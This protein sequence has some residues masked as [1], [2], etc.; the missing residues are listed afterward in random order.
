MAQELQFRRMLPVLQTTAAIFLGG[1]GLWL[2]NSILSRTF[3]GDS[4]LWNSTARFHVWP[5]PLKFEEVLHM[6]AFLAG[7]LLSWPLDAYWPGLPEWVSALPVLP[8]VALL[9]YRIGSWLDRRRGVNTYASTIKG[10]W[11]LLAMFCVVC[12]AASSVPRRVGGYVSY[13]PLGT[14]IWIVAV[15]GTAGFKVSRGNKSHPA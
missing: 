9:W 13:F 2:R 12:A 8:C 15:V 4:T 6:P 3:W 14:V 5:W 1:W 11:L 7:A 10:Q